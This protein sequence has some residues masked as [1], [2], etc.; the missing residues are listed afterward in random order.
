MRVPI[1]LLSNPDGS[2]WLTDEQAVSEAGRP[3][4]IDATGHIY[5]PCEVLEPILVKE[6]TCSQAFY[7]AAYNAGYQV[8]WLEE[9]I[10][11]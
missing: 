7:E 3:V 10:T 1:L 9:E 5:R 6:G 4:L 8:V 11:S 2:F